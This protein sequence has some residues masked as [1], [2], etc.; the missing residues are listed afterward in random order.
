MRWLS[1]P[2]EVDS[3]FPGGNI[4]VDKITRNQIDLRP[5]L[6]DSG[7]SCFYYYFRLHG[8]AGHT[9]RFTFPRGD[10]IGVRGPAVSVDGGLTWRWLGA[11]AVEVNSF[12]FNMPASLPEVRFSCGMPYLQ[13]NLEQFLSPYLGMYPRLPYLR[14]EVLC[15][16]RQGRPVELL[17]LG[18]LAGIAPYQILL[19]CRH[20]SCEMMANYALEGILQTVLGNS[21]AGKWLR[22]NAAFCVLPFMDKDG[23]EEG[24]QGK[25]RR[26]HDHHVDYGGIPLY[27]EVRALK[28]RL[29]QWMGGKLDVCLDLH[30]PGIKGEYNEFVYF[31]GEPEPELWE[32]VTEFSTILEANLQGAIPYLR[33]H[34]LPYGERWNVAPEGGLNSSTGW[35]KTLEGVKLVSTLEIPYADASGVEVNPDSARLL[36]VDIATALA[37]YLQK[38]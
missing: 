6:R 25:H 38:K 1:E 23:V 7:E 26:P 12:T 15:N 21:D 22:Q 20:H 17:H 4:I 24:D 35:V 29:P 19:T 11:Q 36:G 32:K 3:D 8:A 13:Y 27:P 28:R 14:K 16:S 37:I 9:L 33:S 5:D 34:N 31:V 2:L 18:A 10:V 30:C